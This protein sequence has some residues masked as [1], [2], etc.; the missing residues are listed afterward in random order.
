VIT[1]DVGDSVKPKGSL[2]SSFAEFRTTKN[3]LDLAGKIKELGYFVAGSYL[4]TNGAQAITDAQEKKFFGKLSLP[5]SDEAK[6]VGSFGYNEADVRYALATSSNV[7]SQPY[8]TRYGNLQ[9]NVEKNDYRWNAAFKYNHQDITTDITSISTGTLVSSTVNSNVYKGISLNGSM[10]I[11]DYGILVMGADFDWHTLKSNR[12]LDSSKSIS[13]QAPYANHTLEW[14]DW[15]FITGVRF[16]N[17]DQF[18]SQTSPSFGTVYHFQDSRETLIRTKFSRGFNAPPLLWIFN[19]DPSLLVGA[20]PDLKAERSTAYEAGL[21]TKFFSSLGAELNFYRVDVKDAI[22][23][24]FDADN[25]VFVQ[26][27]FRKFRR[28]GGELLLNY[29]INDD[30]ALYGSGAF[31]DVE[32]K[33]TGETVRDQGIARQKF[34]FGAH[35]KNKQG[36]GF[37]LSGYYNRW[38]SSPSRA[39]DRKPIFDMKL[40][41]EFKDLRDNIDVET[42]LNI[43]NLT[44]SKYWSSPTFPIPK[45][46]FEGGFSVKF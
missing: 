39:N 17:N 11:S 21:E 1:K 2:T 42:F 38:S 45:R 28:L 31:N 19:D 41:K 29:H 36:F 8:Y 44:N 40:T 24:V 43:H 20:N 15:E 33:A 13:M 34:T 14:N 9:L 25:V 16:D 7:T 22:A 3:S 23:L 46:Y 27:N 32:N 10:D 37:N 35:Y 26:R 18:G 6:L 30:L 12:F 5:L 4:N